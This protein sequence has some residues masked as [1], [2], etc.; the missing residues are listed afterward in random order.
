MTFI[1]LAK[2]KFFGTCSNEQTEF[3]NCDNSITLLKKMAV[4]K[5]AC[6]IF[7]MQGIYMDTICKFSNE[8]L[9]LLLAFLASQQI[10]KG[11]GAGGKIC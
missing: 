9:K 10:S 5:Y 11:L 4:C 1:Y 6:I 8:R 7:E 3:D 2:G